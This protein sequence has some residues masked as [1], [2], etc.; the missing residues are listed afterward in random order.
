MASDRVIWECIIGE[1]GKHNHSSTVRTIYS[2]MM[3]SP[4]GSKS[5]GISPPLYA[6]ARSSSV[7][8]NGLFERVIICIAA[9]MSSSIKCWDNGAGMST[10][11]FDDLMVDINSSGGQKEDQIGF[12]S[13]Q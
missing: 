2:K 11:N 4:S 10:F 12:Q 7:Q 3:P 13:S 1:D 8:F 9:E 6:R 5:A